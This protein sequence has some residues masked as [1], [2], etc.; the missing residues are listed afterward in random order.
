MY[1][2]H[3]NCVVKTLEEVSRVEF[4]SCL[5]EREEMLRG[6]WR[7]GDGGYGRLGAGEIGGLLTLCVCCV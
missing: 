5:G 7:M 6:G 4:Y 2:K 3:G 1:D